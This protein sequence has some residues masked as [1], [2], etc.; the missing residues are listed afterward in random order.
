MNR[1]PRVRGATVSVRSGS[2]EDIDEVESAVAVHLIEEVHLAMPFYMYCGLVQNRPYSFL[3]DSAAVGGRLGRYSF[4]GADPFLVLK[5][6]RQRGCPLGTGEITIIRMSGGSD[7]FRPPRVS[8]YLGDPFEQIRWHLARY[9]PSASAWPGQPIPFLG[10]AVGYLGYEMLYFIEQI[11]DRGEDDLELPDCYLQFVDSVLAHDHVADR[12]FLSVVGRGPDELIA[13]RRG[14]QVL[15]RWIAQIRAYKA[16]GSLLAPSAERNVNGPAERRARGFRHPVVR[17]H[18]DERRYAQMVSTVKRR[19]A[20]G[21]VFEVCTSHRLEAAFHGDPWCLYLNLRRIN[22]AAFAAFLRFPEAGVVCSSP[23]RFLRVWPDGSAESRPIKGTRPRGRTARRDKRL[24]RQLLRSAKD[25]AENVMIVDLVRNDFGRACRFGSIHV[26]ELMTIE[27]HATVFQMV[28]TVR[29]QLVEGKDPID[30]IRACFPGGS[31]TGAPKIEAMKIID[32]LEPVK[33]GIYSGSI[34][35]LGFGGDVDLNIV[36]R[37]I[38]L[39]DGWAYLQVGGAIVA[40]SDPRSE[41]AESM[42]KAAALIA[43]IRN[44]ASGQANRPQP[45]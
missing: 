28:S 22:P 9:R 23:E 35:Y 14:C 40:D 43:A 19:I 3:L 27:D 21:D 30:L 6:K 2:L 24:R 36:I 26:P 33:R 10:G 38:I 31:M 37:T 13:R 4:L 8:R 1:G 42:D 15:D 5:A 18:F 20:A 41:Y 25:R 29:G 17:S 44:C 34:G 39:K 7:E 45:T 12:S 16:S 11:P 32:E